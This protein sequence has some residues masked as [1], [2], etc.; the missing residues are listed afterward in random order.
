MAQ[1]SVG[2]KTPRPRTVLT[3]GGTGIPARL[4]RFADRDAR[5]HR[6]PVTALRRNASF[7][8]L[9]LYLAITLLTAGVIQSAVV[10]FTVYLV[11]V[12]VRA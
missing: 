11:R 8:A 4:R 2:G 10:M 1:P 5:S 6:P 12:L 3:G 9:W 7:R